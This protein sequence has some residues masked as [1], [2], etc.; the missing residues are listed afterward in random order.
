MDITG[1]FIIG[2][3]NDNVLRPISMRYLAECIDR[4]KLKLLLKLA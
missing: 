1:S 2:L 3:K 4:E